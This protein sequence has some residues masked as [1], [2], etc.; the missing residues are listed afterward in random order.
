[1][2]PDP[3]SVARPVLVGHL[4]VTLPVVAIMTAGY[5]GAGAVLGPRTSLLGGAAGVVVAWL[6]WSLA[7]PR[8]RAWALRS[9]ADSEKLQRWAV[10]TGLV[11]PRG[12]V[13]EKTELPP[14]S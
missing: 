10:A 12:S 14:R 2:A 13:F 8:W 5:F 7:V 11:W 4:I 1:M 3:P 6:Y 9:G